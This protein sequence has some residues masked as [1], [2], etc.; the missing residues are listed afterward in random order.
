[1]LRAFTPEEV[2][3]WAAEDAA[4]ADRCSWSST[5]PGFHVLR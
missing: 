1:M 5:G 2:E 3:R 4:A